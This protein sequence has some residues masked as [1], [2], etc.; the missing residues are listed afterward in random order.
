MGLE[1]TG[2]PSV[3]KDSS[4][5]TKNESVVFKA[6]AATGVSNSRDAES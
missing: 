3:H 4:E 5:V 6:P 2:E 1:A